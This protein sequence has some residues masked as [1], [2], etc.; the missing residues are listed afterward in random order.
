LP[1]YLREN[2]GAPFIIAF[3]VMLIVCAVLLAVGNETVA[4]E[5]TIYAFYCLVAGIIIQFIVFL[6]HGDEG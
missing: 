5:L 3:Q 1:K 2:P 4:N 6:K